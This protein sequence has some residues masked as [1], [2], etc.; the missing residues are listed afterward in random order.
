[1]HFPDLELSRLFAPRSIAVVGASTDPSKAGHQ[2]VRSLAA[3]PGPLFAVN[4]AGADVLGKPGCRRLAD[5]PEP[6][7]LAVLVL[8]PEATVEVLEECGACGIHA[9]VLCSGGFAETGEAGAE[10][11]Q[12]AVE[13]AERHHI[14][15][16]GPNTSGFANPPRQ[17]FASFVP[18]I[19]QVPPGSLAVVA[20]SGGMNH[21]LGFLGSNDGLGF[22]HLIGLGNSANL[23]FPDVLD[24]LAG[25]DTTTAVALHLEGVRDGAGLTR[26]IRELSARKPVVAYKVGR[27]DVQAF[28][29]SHTGALLGDQRLAVAALRQAGA[30]VVDSSTGAIDALK[31]LSTRR[32]TTDTTGVAVVTGQAGPGI[33]IADVLRAAGMSVPALGEATRARIAE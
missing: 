21:A 12:Q 17:V 7:D 15:L 31:A 10:L 4:R 27:A 6:I 30:V 8:P 26:A 5:I 33:V 2:M 18:A 22:S 29:R 16:L 20:Q 14:W 11:Q 23:D 25:D 3:F 28:A 24:Y 1:M 9:A 32:L 13:I 19:A